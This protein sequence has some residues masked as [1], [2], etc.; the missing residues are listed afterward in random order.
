MF[1]VTQM[2]KGTKSNA[3]AR[4]GSAGFIVPEPTTRYLLSQRSTNLSHEHKMSKKY[5]RSAN[6]R[7]DLV[8]T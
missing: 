3:L 8:T 5:S 2:F 4:K 1:R 6:K 7:W